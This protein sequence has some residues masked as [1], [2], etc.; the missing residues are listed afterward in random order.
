MNRDQCKTEL[1]RIRGAITAGSFD[2]DTALDALDRAE[3]ALDE[4][5]S[6]GE[7]P[8]ARAGGHTPIASGK[9]L[10]PTPPV[11]PMAPNPNPPAPAAPPHPAG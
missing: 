2:R 9:P 1:G 3:A 4:K 5:K 10:E 8:G 11:S 6:D 7:G